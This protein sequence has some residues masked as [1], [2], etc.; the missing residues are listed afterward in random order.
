MKEGITTEKPAA[1]IDMT[2]NYTSP[3][4]TWINDENPMYVEIV[5]DPRYVMNQSRDVFNLPAIS[6]GQYDYEYDTNTIYSYENQER[7]IRKTKSV[8]AGMET[9]FCLDYEH[10]ES[11]N[12]DRDT[13]F[14]VVLNEGSP[15]RYNF[16][17]EWVL[18]EFDDVEVFG[19]WDHKDTTD[20]ARFKGSLHISKLQSKLK[21][22]KFTFIIPIA[23]GWVT[24]KYIEKSD[25][26]VQIRIFGT[27]GEYEN[28]R[29][30]FITNAIVKNLLNLPIIINK[31]VYF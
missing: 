19:K 24:S 28:Y 15:S 17:K 3:I 25:S 27:Y 8:Y 4:T 5:N 10:Q 30:K 31:N 18:N 9:A 20:D 13:N 1:V 6:L 23:K 2:K 16:L 21:D 12:T 7:R 11:I 29:F 22:V 14:M 26:I